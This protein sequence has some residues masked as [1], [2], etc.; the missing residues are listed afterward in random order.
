M[1]GFSSQATMIYTFPDITIKSKIALKYKQNDFA[2]WINGAEV[3]TD[4][5]GI[6][7]TGLNVLQFNTGAG[8]DIFCGKCKDLRVYN[9]ALTDA[10][11]QALTTL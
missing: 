5:S 1:S 2:L 6:T 3:L 7:P 8:G 4:L 9:T 10:E 11:L